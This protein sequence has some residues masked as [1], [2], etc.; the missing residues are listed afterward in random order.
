MLAAL[1][2]APGADAGCT[3]PIRVPASPLGQMM[4]IRKDT[5]RVE[6]IYADL[7]R[8]RGN[9]VGCVFDFPLVEPR[10]RAEKLI[11][12]G[13][14]DLFVG[15]ARTPERDAWGRFVP[16]MEVEWKLVSHDSVRP[17]PASVPELLALPGVRFSAVRGYNHSPAYRDLIAA[18]ADRQVLEYVTDPQT[19]VRKMQMGH[20]DFSLMPPGTLNGALDAAGASPEFRQR[21]R[22]TRLAG[23]PPA[24]TG[25]YLSGALDR[26]DA[27]LLRHM[28]EQIARDG[29]LLARLRQVLPA[30]DAAAYA[31]LR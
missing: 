16:L 24:V 9:A 30:E 26:Q 28:L 27:A 3:R 5:G 20:A 8:E 13:E 6:G 10:I 21:V 4:V 18:L 25:V 2:L 7:L 29:V 15:A 19:V 11:A 22:L 1:C 14:M 31:S 17:V 12:G 23:L